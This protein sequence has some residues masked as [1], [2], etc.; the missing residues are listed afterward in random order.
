M[1]AETQRCRAI[2]NAAEVLALLRAAREPFPRHVF[3]NR[4]KQ[5]TT[6]ETM[7][8]HEACRVRTLMQEGLRPLPPPAPSLASPM[9][10]V[11]A[12]RVITGY[13]CFG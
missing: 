9:A 12:L 4:Q 6:T 7:S 10:M 13:F 2:E 1:T 8:L 5:N 3:Q 11:E